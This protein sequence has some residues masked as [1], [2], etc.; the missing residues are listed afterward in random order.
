MVQEQQV[1]SLLSFELLD[2]CFKNVHTEASK[3]NVSFVVWFVELCTTL[4][5][6]QSSDPEVFV[7]YSIQ[8]E[9]FVGS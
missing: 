9:S 2:Q 6:P 8:Y 7:I 5:S 3:N 4:L 1:V